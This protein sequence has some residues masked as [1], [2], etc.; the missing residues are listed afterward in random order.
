MYPNIYIPTNEYRYILSSVHH[1]VRTGVS[2][3][4][5]V[6]LF[7]ASAFFQ[8]G[9][10]SELEEGVTKFRLGLDVWRLSLALCQLGT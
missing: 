7:S 4:R 2:E 6:F 5:L 10:S 3:S 9:G 1:I 8:S